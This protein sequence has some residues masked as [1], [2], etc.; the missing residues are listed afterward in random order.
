MHIYTDGSCIKKQNKDSLGCGGW[1]FVIVSDG[2]A[3]RECSGGELATTNNRME[4]MAVIKALENSVRDVTVHSDSKYVIECAS[5]NWKRN[6]N[7]DLWN[8][9]NFVSQEKNITYIWVKG[10]SGNH[11]NEVA[12]SLAHTYARSLS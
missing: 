9:Y 10:H 2:V 12:D 1:G 5:R 6:K 7:L 8:H 3:I 4:L 11:F